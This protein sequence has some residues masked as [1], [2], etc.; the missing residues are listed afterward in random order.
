MQISYSLDGGRV[1]REY[2]HV[3]D[4]VLVKEELD[5]VGSRGEGAEVGV[6]VSGGEPQLSS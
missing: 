3:R 5:L 4:L 6:E 2:G 1:R